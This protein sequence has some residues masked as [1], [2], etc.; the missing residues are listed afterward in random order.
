VSTDGHR[1]ERIAELFDHALSLGSDA[2]AAFLASLEEQDVAMAV[3][4][5]S[6][7]AAH[8]ADP[9]D[10]DVV[11]ARVLPDVLASL[12]RSI[13]AEP[14]APA[15]TIGRYH[16]LERLGSGGMAEVYRARDLSLDRLVALKVL[17]PYLDRDAD[18]RARFVREARAASALDHPNIA[19]VFE[20]GTEPTAD[21]AGRMFIAMAFY[22]GETIRHKVARGPL[23]VDQA[24]DYAWQTAEGLSAAHDAG[25]VHRDIKPANLIVTDRQHLKILDF[26]IAKFTGHDVT[27]EGSTLGTIAY[28]SP[29]QTYGT[30]V[31]ARTDLWSLGVV[32]YEMLTGVRPFPAEGGAALLEAIRHDRPAPLRQLRPDAPEPLERIVERCLC[33]DPAD[34][35]ASA[36][37]L[38]EDL[39]HAGGSSVQPSAAPPHARKRR[40]RQLPGYLADIVRSRRTGLLRIA[41][42]ALLLGAAAIAMIAQQRG[43]AIAFPSADDAAIAV[44]PFAPVVADSALD[45]LGRDLAVSV[46]S[47]LDGIDDLRTV[48]PL[49]VSSRTGRSSEMGAARVRGAA[50]AQAVGASRFMTGT[51]TRSGPAVRVDARLSHATEPASVATVSITG[52]QNDLAGLTDSV[53]LALIRALWRDR[54]AVS[55]IIGATR[56]R[57]VAALRAYL[58]AE[59]LLGRGDMPRAVESFERAFALDSTYWFAYWRSLYPRVWYLSGAPDSARVRQVIEHRHEFPA[60]DRLLVESWMADRLTERLRL[61]RDAIMRFDSYWP[62]WYAY[63]VELV[64]R[65]PYLGTT[66]EDARA[67]LERTLELNPDFASAWSRLGWV[68]TQ[69]RDTATMSHTITAFERASAGV[70]FNAVIPPHAAVFTSLVRSGLPAPDSLGRIVDWIFSVSEPLVIDFT[71]VPVAGGLPQV[72]LG[73]NA[74]ILTRGPGAR[75]THF[76]ERGNAL[77]WVSRGAWDSALVAVDRAADVWPEPRTALTAYGLAVLGSSLGFVPAAEAV[78]RRPVAM[79]QSADGSAEA[80]AEL[81][82]LDG[83]LAH[84]LNDAAGLARARAELA[85]L[86]APYADALRGSLAAF[87]A[88]LAGDRRRAARELARL[89]WDNADRFSPPPLSTLYPFLVPA[90]RLNAA[91]WLRQIGED[92]EA[93]RLLTWSEGLGRSF[94]TALNVTFGWIG[95]VDRAEIAEMM[96][97][98][99]R[100]RY[101]Y[102]RFLERHDMPVP[103]L[104]PLLERARAG[105]E[106]T[107]GAR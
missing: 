65:G 41:L 10:L 25:I 28:M 13:A 47:A 81:A 74:A 63:S 60:Q 77:A 49:I 92:G 27:T 33:K 101:F 75:V 84:A 76:V 90:N 98:T 91:Q 17:P 93:A 43:S 82:W 35:Y 100:A 18:A 89:E 80:A 83:I 86:S 24:V 45:R 78:R 64:H 97:Q 23:P 85:P 107:R 71:T 99:D 6:L 72:Q 56:T 2:R 39:L 22:A 52:Q 51:L 11:A 105:V 102:A 37:L 68:S 95:F 69:Q 12:A 96:G 30:Q 21:A 40:A 67:A 57:S 26:G 55:P 3:E 46:S 1:E 4:L 59:R 88:D 38:R 104:V 44:L 16:I 42:P 79:Q 53:S 48:D 34:R 9:E 70:G 54:P 5:R 106:R 14:L 8:D 61:L 87:A 103:G 50:L 29:E 73:L 36:A 7:L 31:D 66:L 32:L 58:D 62:A 94:A 15:Q 20:I 19:V